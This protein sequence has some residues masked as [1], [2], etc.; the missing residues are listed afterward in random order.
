MDAI[1]RV[2][3]TKK[4]E[5]SSPLFFFLLL[6]KDGIAGLS[7]IGDIRHCWLSDDR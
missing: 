6:L 1:S 5:V 4:S 7:R 3:Q 2:F